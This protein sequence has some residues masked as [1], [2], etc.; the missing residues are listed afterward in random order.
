MLDKHTHTRTH[1]P[2]AR[3]GAHLL[4]VP[5]SALILLPT[6]SL[7]V[8]HPRGGSPAARSEHPSTHGLAARAPWLLSL[9]LEVVT[10]SAAA[11]V[12]AATA[13]ALAGVSQAGALKPQ[14]PY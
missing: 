7:A 4:P 6:P 12:A 13:P 9:T 11:A 8:P 3:R 10:K 2:G 5:T 1:S 14:R